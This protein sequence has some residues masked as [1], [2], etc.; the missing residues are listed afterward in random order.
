M[1][2]FLTCFFG[3]LLLCVFV[4]IAVIIFMAGGFLWKVI[5]LAA[6]LAAGLALGGDE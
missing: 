6:V 3:I 2:A 4:Y 5:C 1:R